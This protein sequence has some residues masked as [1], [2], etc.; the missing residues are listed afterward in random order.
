[1]KKKNKINKERINNFLFFLL[2]FY[3]KYKDISIYIINGS[4]NFY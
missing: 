1:M 2:L 3:H 4:K